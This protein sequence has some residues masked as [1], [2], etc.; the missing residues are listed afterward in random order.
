MVPRYVIINERE[1]DEFEK[2]WQ[3]P[4]GYDGCFITFEFA[5]AIDQIKRFA[6]DYSGC[7]IERIDEHGREIVYKN[8]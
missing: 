8:E 1:R 5:D 4:F 7:S 6:Y 3:L 2:E